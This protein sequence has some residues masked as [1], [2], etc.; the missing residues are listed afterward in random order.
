MIAGLR[1][2]VI[3]S[4]LDRYDSFSCSNYFDISHSPHGFDMNPSDWVDKYD[5]VL[6]E[7]EKAITT[8]TLDDVISILEEIVEEK[9]NES[10]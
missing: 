5:E 10:T 1:F 9:T 2:E 4:L 6:L 7:Y 3:Q 8:Q